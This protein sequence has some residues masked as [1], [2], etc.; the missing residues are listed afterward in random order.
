M[1]LPNAIP[2]YNFHKTKYGAELLIDVVTLKDIKRYLPQKLLH[3]LTYY[4]I[5]F[6]P[7]GKDLFLLTNKNTR[8]RP[9]T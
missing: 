9:V 4:D 1:A 8:L 6:L 3:R 2:E 5:T 7:K